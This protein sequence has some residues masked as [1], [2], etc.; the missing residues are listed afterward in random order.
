MGD[1]RRV[2]NPEIIFCFV[3]AF[4]SLFGNVQIVRSIT[5]FG[6]EGD[7]SRTGYSDR[8]ENRERKNPLYG[9]KLKRLFIFCG[10]L[11]IFNFYI[12]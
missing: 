9:I 11:Y 8:V 12:I 5:E 1:S 6:Q 10:L 2:H 3:C 4:I 7:K